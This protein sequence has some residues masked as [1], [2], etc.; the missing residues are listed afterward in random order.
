MQ[1][2]GEFLKIHVGVNVKT[3]Q[4]RCLEITDDKSH[5]SK[6]FISLV[7]QSKQF[8]NV[9]K[10]L[11]DGAHDTNNDFSYLYYDNEIMPAIKTKKIYQLILTVIPKGK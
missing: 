6:C 9:T 1:K 7:E 2:R 4:I 11:A 10:T 5:D 8:G 3:K